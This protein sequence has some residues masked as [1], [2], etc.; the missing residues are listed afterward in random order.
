MTRRQNM[1]NMCSSFNPEVYGNIV[2]SIIKMNVDGKLA[3]SYVNAMSCQHRFALC[4][5]LRCNETREQASNHTYVAPDMFP[6]SE[7]VP[8]CAGNITRN[9]LTFRNSTRALLPLLPSAGRPGAM[10]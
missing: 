10:L 2:T 9:K 7:V 1:F 4:S 3:T 6:T 5:V 8:F